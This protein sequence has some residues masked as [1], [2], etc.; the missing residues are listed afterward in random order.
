MRVLVTGATGFVGSALINQ[1]G[2]DAQFNVR[3]AMR[4][5]VHDLPQN[6]EHAVV[7]DYGPDVVWQTALAGVDVIVHL[8]GR[9]HIM[10]D[11][12][13][14]PITEFRRVNVNGT[15]N[16][17]K[18]A[19]EAGV[20]RFVFLS[21]V[22]V[23]GEGCEKPYTE[24]DP[25]QPFNPYAQSK[26][27]AEREL[28]SVCHRAELE[29]VILRPP[30]VYGP[31]VKA[32]FLTLLHAVYRGIPLPFAAVNNR[33]SL[34]SIHNL[35]DVIIRCIKHPLAAGET[36]LV[37][38]DEDLS[39]RELIRRLAAAMDRKPRLFSIP[40]LVGESALKLVGREDIW[41]RLFGSLQV[42]CDKAKSLIGW[43][44]PVSLSEGL[45]E[46]SHWYMETKVRR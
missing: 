4:R 25:P 45:E 42:S 46:V 18:Q 31:G 2:N 15:S 34:V 35:V 30:L 29:V 13:N 16:L 10:R 37:S 40:P 1:L 20:R 33:R 12:A 28:A 23:N 5:E 24:T 19:V 21:S 9:V 6:I 3:A 44:P 14:D 26:W 8:A 7:G 41:Q 39:T 27:E 17:V 22:K 11:K 43:Q 36:F 32:N 38:D